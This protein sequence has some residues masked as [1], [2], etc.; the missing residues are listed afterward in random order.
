MHLLLRFLLAFVT[1]TLFTRVENNDE[2]FTIAKHLQFEW[3]DFKVEERK[4]NGE[5]KTWTMKTILVHSRNET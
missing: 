4:Q 3:S 1:R 2:K 5:K